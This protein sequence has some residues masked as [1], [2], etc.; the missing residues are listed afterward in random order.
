MSQTI[1]IVALRSSA[2]TITALAELLID[3]V[4]S[5]GSVSFMHPLAPD[6]AAAF[7]TK[8]LAR[9]D[10]GERV[11]LGAMEDGEL[12]CTGTP[13]LDCPPDQAHRCQ[14]AYMIARLSQSGRVV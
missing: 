8:S 12:I 7:W 3:T 2:E 4:A 10:A 5:G 6:V 11:V 13:L 14:I 9:A 1:N